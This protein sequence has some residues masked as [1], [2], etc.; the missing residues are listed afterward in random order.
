MNVIATM[1]EGHRVALSAE[2]RSAFS[3]LETK[4]DT[5]HSKVEDYEQHIQS[6]S[7]AASERIK[8]LEVTLEVT[9]RLKATAMD[10]EES[11]N[12]GVGYNRVLGNVRQEAKTCHE[13]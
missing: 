2:F 10:L 4:L 11:L 12:L 9:R 13:E 5:I 1:L 3:T 8:T 6:N 7:N